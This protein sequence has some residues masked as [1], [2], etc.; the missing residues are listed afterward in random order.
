MGEPA[1]M[2]KNSRKPRRRPA[3]LRTK[4]GCLTCEFDPFRAPSASFSPTSDNHSVDDEEDEF[5][6][7]VSPQLTSV[8]SHT[9][10]HSPPLFD[11]MR[12]V[13]VPQLVRPATDSQ[14]IKDFTS[15][16]LQLAHSTPFFMDALLACSAAEIKENDAF[17]RRRAESTTSKLS[18]GM[19]ASL[20]QD[21][22]PLAEIIALRTVLML[23]I[24]EASTYSTQ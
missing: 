10:I 23:Y 2:V 5:S 17:H 22:S 11:F 15:G 14:Y 24:Y 3:H 1:Q 6:L 20:A 21:D 4:T 16:S 19:R 13:F 7:I 18:Q 12:T 9:K 8:A